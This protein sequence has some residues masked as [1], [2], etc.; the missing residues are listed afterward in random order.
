MADDRFIHWL[1]RI[2]VNTCPLTIYS[3]VSELKKRHRR[4]EI[5]G[6]MYEMQS[7]IPIAIGNEVRSTL[8][9]LIVPRTSYLVPK[10][11]CLVIKPRD[12]GSVAAFDKGDD[13]NVAVVCIGESFVYILSCEQVGDLWY[14]VGM[15]ADH[16]GSTSV[17]A[18]EGIYHL[19]FHSIINL[20]FKAFLLR[21]WSYGV[22][23]SFVTCCIDGVYR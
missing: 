10:Y 12:P 21:Q 18:D 4:Y 16:H 9:R 7:T 14:G 17:L 23:R 15:A 5:Q 8:E 13:E 3:H 2:E 22:L 20:H 1:P 19:G 6:T 11:S